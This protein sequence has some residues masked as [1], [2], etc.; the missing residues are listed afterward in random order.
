VSIKKKSDAGWCFDNS[1]A[2]LPEVFFSPT[3][4]EPVRHAGQILLNETVAKDLGLTIEILRLDGPQVFAGNEIPSGA[5]PIAQAYAG[6]QFGHFTNLGDGRAILLGEHLTPDKQR[7]DVQLKGSGRTPYSRS[8]DGRAALGP[9][10]REYIIS[11]G[12][13]SLGIP[14]TRSLSVTATGESVL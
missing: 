11:E 3:K 8:G 12:M 2:H 4:P 14:T 13:E 9:M 7:V 6:H 10:I 5:M 1:F